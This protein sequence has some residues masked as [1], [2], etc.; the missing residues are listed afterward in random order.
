MQT[1]SIGY[2]S[3]LD[4][5]TYT[6]N[7]PLNGTDPTGNDGEANDTPDPG[8]PGQTGD[9]K[10]DSAVRNSGSTTLVS[11][12]VSASSSSGGASGGGGISNVAAPPQNSTGPGSALNNDNFFRDW[13]DET[14][15]NLAIK[16]AILAAADISIGERFLGTN[17]KIYEKFLGNQYVTT[18]Q[19]TKLFKIGGIGMLGVGSA[20]D[21]MKLG[22]GEISAVAASRNLAVGITGVFGGLPGAVF[23]TGYGLMDN[24]YP[25]GVDGFLDA[26][27]QAPHAEG[28]L[29]Y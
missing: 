27:R 17:L 5:Y 28:F 22:K 23:S 14:G 26:P 19:L 2:Q 13:S 12:H 24:F 15:K 29:P 7:D 6:G 4:L 1:D 20:V 11:S 10:W 25:G 9:K 21:I 3:D 16:G 18:F 8:G